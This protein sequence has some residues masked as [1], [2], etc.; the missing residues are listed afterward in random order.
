VRWTWNAWR[1]S[2]GPR[3]SA[4]PEMAVEVPAGT[5]LRPAGL[6]LTAF[7]PGGYASSAAERTPLDTAV[8]TTTEAS[9]TA[10][11]AADAAVV[12]SRPPRPRS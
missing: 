4:V 2:V 5:L 1:A 10:S 6:L 3:R 11:T 12:A 9:V 7:A 8:V